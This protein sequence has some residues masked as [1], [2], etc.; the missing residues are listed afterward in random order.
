M[1]ILSFVDNCHFREEESLSDHPVREFD[2]FVQVLV[3]TVFTSLAVPTGYLKVIEEVQ[4]L[5]NRDSVSISLL[6]DDVLLL[7]ILQVFNLNIECLHSFFVQ[8]ERLID[9][10]CPQFFLA[11]V[12][13]R[14]EAMLALDRQ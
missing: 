5:V 3:S 11:P 8:I 14:I 9:L 7:G 12:M 13:P 6:L 2:C 1:S 10:G 4:Q